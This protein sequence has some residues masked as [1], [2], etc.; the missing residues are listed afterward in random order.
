MA[1]PNATGRQDK[2]M[3][4]MIFDI[5][6]KALRTYAEPKAFFPAWCGVM[7]LVYEGF[8]PPLVRIKEQITRELDGLQAE[9]PGTIWSK[10]TIGAVQDGRRITFEQL[11]TLRDLCDQ[12]CQQIQRESWLMEIHSL[13]LVNFA[14]RSLERRVAVYDIPL[15][16]EHDP[17]PPSAM[18]RA[19]VDETLSQLSHDD[20]ELY[21]YWEHDVARD[22]NR[23]SHYRSSY[24]ETTLVYDLPP[25]KPSWLAGFKNA[26]DAKLP[27]LYGW[28]EDTS[29]HMTIRAIY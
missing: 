18:Q 12:Y 25:Q 22:G 29:L 3:H 17:S 9:N 11:L 1:V 23:V 7:T 24:Y 5:I 16:S 2:A 19:A 10:T 20:E 6:P 8:T 28:F 21:K 14:C 13:K 15:Q 26:V 4:G 27:G